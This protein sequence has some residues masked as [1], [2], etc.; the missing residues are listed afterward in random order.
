MR[1]I[2]GEWLKRN[3][4]T[5]KF[6]SPSWR[7]LVKAVAEVNRAVAENIAQAHPGRSVNVITVLEVAR[8][9]LQH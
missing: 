5:E 1:D 2:L 4:K 7:M 6:G 9:V 8:P 3:Y